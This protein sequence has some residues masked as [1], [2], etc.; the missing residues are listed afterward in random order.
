VNPYP[1]CT[2]KGSAALVPL[3]WLAAAP[4][5]GAGGGCWVDVFDRPDFAGSRVHIE[6]PAALPSLAGL[7]G[8]DWSDRIE[9]LEVGP[10]ASVTAYRNEGFR[11]DT[12]AGPAYHGEALKAWGETP[13]AYGDQAITFGS[14]KREHHLGELRLH[15]AIRALKIDCR[16]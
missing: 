9:S 15:R 5:M 12:E 3:Y 6:G 1:V 2:K 10:D 16:P 7:D 13:E 4:A 8:R 11:V 14:G